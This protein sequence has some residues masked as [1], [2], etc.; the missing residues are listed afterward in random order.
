[1]H[2]DLLADSPAERPSEGGSRRAS[3]KRPL[4][5]EEQLLVP[6]SAGSNGPGRDPDEKTAK[7]RRRQAHL[8]GGKAEPRNALDHTLRPSR[9]RPAEAQV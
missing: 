3:A 2:T 8:S 7:R 4:A 5:V 6:S 9:F 1:M